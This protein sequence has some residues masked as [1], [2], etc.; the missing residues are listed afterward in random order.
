VRQL[1]GARASDVAR[2]LAHK[3]APRNMMSAECFGDSR[4]VASNDTPQGRAKN[5]RVEIVIVAADR[6]Y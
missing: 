4:P 2:F 1:S 6:Q 3:G 5:L